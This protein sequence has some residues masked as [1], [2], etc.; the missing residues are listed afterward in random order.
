MC[1][2]KIN[3]FLVIILLLLVDLA[4]SELILIFFAMINNLWELGF[5]KHPIPSGYP[6]GSYFLKIYVN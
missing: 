2:L 3:L 6:T 4:Q 5:S 1:L